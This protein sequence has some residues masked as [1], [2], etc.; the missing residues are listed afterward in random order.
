MLEFTYCE[1]GPWLAVDHPANTLS[2][3]IFF[4][5]AFGLYFKYRKDKTLRVA[6]MLVAGIGVGSSIWHYIANANLL[7]LDIGTISL[8]TIWYLWQMLRR[9][10]S[11]SARLIILTLF[12]LFIVNGV[13]GF[14]LEPL[15]P[16]RT[17]SFLLPALGMIFIGIKQSAP[18]IKRAMILSG[19]SLLVAMGF[20]VTDIHTCDIIP[21]G[22]HFLWHTFA[23]LALLGPLKLMIDHCT[24]SE[25]LTSE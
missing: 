8:F 24:C 7:A 23:G 3:A 22:T 15:L 14:L 4:I 25:G 2:N 12:T 5:I 17:G 18:D 10:T 1:T 6:A 19:V 16:M 13:L 11:L 21:I 20:R 9:L